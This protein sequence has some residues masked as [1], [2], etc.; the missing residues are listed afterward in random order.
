MF[1]A[2]RAAAAFLIL[3]VSYPVAA[4]DQASGT[5]T[6]LLVYDSG[7][8]LVK[9]SST[10]ANRPACST[11]TSWTFAMSTGASGAAGQLAS[12]L[13]AQARAVTFK[14]AGTGTC[15]VSSQIE[16]LSYIWTTS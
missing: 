11:N 8:V 4:S 16:N 6:D 10:P 15:T 13:S 2:F 12:L 1:N 9:M 7:I 3:S 5:I 14:Y